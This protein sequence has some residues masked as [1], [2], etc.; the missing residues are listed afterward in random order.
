MTIV[1]LAARITGLSTDT[2]PTNVQTNRL[3]L[4][5]DTGDTF[6][7]DGASWGIIGGGTMGDI[8]FLATK[9]F[10]GKLR[11]DTDQITTAGIAIDV[12]TLTAAGGKDMYL[13]KAKVKLFT[14]SSSSLNATIVV[15]ANNVIQESVELKIDGSPVTNEVYTFIVTGVKVTTGQII[16]IES[17]AND[18]SIEIS[19]TLTCWEEDTGDSPA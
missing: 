15:K 3:F 19:G 5:T 6:L 18:S 4:E 17:T 9:E 8:Q 13:A 14:G 12:A 7:F 11:E 16:K 10:D 1:Y 2:K